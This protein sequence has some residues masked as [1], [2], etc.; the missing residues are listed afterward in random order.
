[1]L[2]WLASQTVTRLRGTP[3]T[4]DYSNAHLDWSEPDRLTL[5]NCSIQPASGD[6]FNQGRDA[7]T[8]RWKWRCGDAQADVTALDRIEWRELVYDIDGSVQVWEDT[9]GNGLDHVMAILR[10]VDG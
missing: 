9:T 2:P 7:I 10:R 1:M 5:S 3:V 4:D 6:E 8:T